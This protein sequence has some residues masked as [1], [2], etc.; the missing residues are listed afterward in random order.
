MLVYLV[1][2]HN[3]NVNSTKLLMSIWNSHI[4]GVKKPFTTLEYDSSYRKKEKKSNEG[5]SLNV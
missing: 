2:I 3:Q 5:M 1:V 4:Q